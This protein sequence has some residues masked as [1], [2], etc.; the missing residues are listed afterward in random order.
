MKQILF[1]VGAGHSGSTL[2]SK[3]L[4]AHSKIFALSEISQFY[5]DIKNENAHCGC[6]S[7]L[8]NCSFWDDIENRLSS[9]LGYGIKTNPDLFRVARDPNKNSIIDKILFRISRF[10]AINFSIYFPIIKDK[11]SN[12][13]HLFDVLFE[14]TG[15]DVLVDSS[16]SARRAYLLKNFFERYDFKCKV[17]H[18]VR[19]GRAV[20][21]SY[22]K[23]YYRVNLV[24]PDT[25]QK[26]IKTFYAEQKRPKEE[27]VR[28][29]KRDNIESLF[30]H[31]YLGRKEDYF[32]LR[33]ED[34]A[35][36]PEYSLKEILSFLGLEYEP[37]M[38]DLNRFQ[39]HMVSGNASRLNAEK[40][41]KPFNTW[42]TELTD[43]EIN[44]FNKKAGW[45]NQKYGYK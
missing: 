39:N 40:I 45:L 37:E 19:D 1:I 2:L 18:L 42:E 4:N 9:K 20:F 36:Y 31:K 34:F 27:I 14:K 15:A 43:K 3:A 17:I 23:G 8:R 32:L 26:E 6:G 30:Y 11:L 41:Q 21:Y 12:I 13:K 25:G 35:N 38:L 5:E 7:K 44:Y 33:Y 10:F 22:S 28:I 29:W 24:N 16:K